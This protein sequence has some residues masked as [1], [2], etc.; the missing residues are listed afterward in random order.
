MEQA[1]LNGQE[2]V[3]FITD[4]TLNHEAA[5]FLAEHPSERFTRYSRQLLIGTRRQQL[6]SELDRDIEQF[7]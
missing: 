7:T 6:L 5:A 1:F 4:L 2:M 3:V